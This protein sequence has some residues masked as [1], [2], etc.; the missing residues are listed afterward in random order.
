MDQI[1]AIRLFLEV[2]DQQS[3]TA[4]AERLGLSKALV[5]KHI[6]LLEKRVG[7]RLLNRSTRT[8]VLT[9]AGQRF[10]EK[11]RETVASWQVMLEA[12]T[13][14]N[15]RP[16]GVLRIAGPKVFGEGVLTRAASSFVAVQPNLKI[17]LHLEERRV[18]V[19]AE[20][21]DL[22]IRVGLPTDSSLIGIALGPYPYVLTASPVYL[23][24][25]KK[26]EHPTDLKD[27]ACIV[28]SGLTYEGQW[29]FH[30][31]GETVRIAP[32]AL[33][34]VNTNAPVVRFV[35]DGHGIG[36]CMRQSVEWEIEA[37]RLVPVL[38]DWQVEQHQIH[39]L[40]PHRPMMPAK[41]RLF[42]DHLKRELK[43]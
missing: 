41:T 9:E 33:L 1:D 37:G 7:A 25:R 11:A 4:A 39:A 14:D 35:R 5:S 3:F 20:G 32:P 8:V 36:I 21:F 18:D 15:E 22:A 31:G 12:A 16:H 24:G 17:D 26:P 40:I 6:A 29:R 30:R 13:E 34:R 23:A 2:A 10:A 27:H 38:E 42:I 28:N 19:I 43:G